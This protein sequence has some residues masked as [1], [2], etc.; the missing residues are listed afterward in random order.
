LY[1]PDLALSW[2]ALLNHASPQALK[3]SIHLIK[4]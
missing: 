1:I 4:I 2:P 3:P